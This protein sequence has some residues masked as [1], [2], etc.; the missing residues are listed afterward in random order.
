M[1]VTYH[2]VDVKKTSLTYR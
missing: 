1:C 2:K